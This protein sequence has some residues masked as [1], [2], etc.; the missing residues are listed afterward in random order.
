M[1]RYSATGVPLQNVQ[2]SGQSDSYRSLSTALSGFSDNLFKFAQIQQKKQE[3]K[4]VVIG[5]NQALKE[6]GEGTFWHSGGTSKR[7]VAHDLKSYELFI[8]DIENASS[9]KLNEFKGLYRNDPNA[10]SAA[11]DGHKK[12]MLKN[13]P[14]VWRAQYEIM[15]DAKKN[16]IRGELDTSFY[17]DQDVAINKVFGERVTDRRD[18]MR[19]NLQKSGYDP[20]VVKS[21]LEQFDTWANSVTNSSLIP[22]STGG[23]PLSTI[24]QVKIDTRKEIEFELHY[25]DFND[26]LKNQGSKAAEQHLDD[27]NNGRGKRYFPGGLSDNALVSLIAKRSSENFAVSEQMFKSEIQDEYHSKQ[28]RELHRD[29]VATQAALLA[30]SGQLTAD[31]VSQN[32]QVLGP[33][34]TDKYMQY[35]KYGTPKPGGASNPLLELYLTEALDRRADPDMVRKRGELGVQRKEITISALKNVLNHDEDRRFKS[36]DEKVKASLNTL[37]GE[38]GEKIRYGSAK[39]EWSTWKREHPDATQKEA[40]AASD[41]IIHSAMLVEGAKVPTTLNMPT[42][43]DGTRDE[44]FKLPPEQINALKQKQNAVTAKKL[45]TTDKEKIVN[46]I[47]WQE[48]ARRFRRLEEARKIQE[49]L[50]QTRQQQQN[51]GGW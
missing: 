22:G 4:D 10:F 5:T 43:F 21:E 27:L 45:G 23:I 7:D 37:F 47:E 8:M 50:Q 32:A 16:L 33:A 6:A 11:A 2:F 28:R 20:N 15:F 51:K 38:T 9:E 36:S 35:A 48:Q 24:E 19:S 46:D 30:H 29:N 17:A 14:D 3:K 42:V 25:R 18:I 39:A 44:Y 40:D 13:I 49:R 31:W 12:G 41:R 1:P 26:I 34:N